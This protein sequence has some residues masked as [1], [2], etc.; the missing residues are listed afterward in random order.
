MKN[1]RGKVVVITGAIRISSCIAHRCWLW[2][3][4]VFH[5]F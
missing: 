4:I 3:N 2:M 5:F 1:F